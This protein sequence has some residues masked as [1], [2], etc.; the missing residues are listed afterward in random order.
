M[1]YKQDVIDFFDLKKN[2]EVPF[3]IE[4]GSSA[5]DWQVAKQI[6][7]YEAHM[8]KKGNFDSNYIE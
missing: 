5:K 4:K 6:I 8:L 7:S 3:V 1:Y 2:P